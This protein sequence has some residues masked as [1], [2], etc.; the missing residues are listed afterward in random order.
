[1]PSTISWPIRTS[2]RRMASLSRTT[3]SASMS[4]PLPGL[5]GPG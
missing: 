5:A 1:L 4:V 3:F 2:V